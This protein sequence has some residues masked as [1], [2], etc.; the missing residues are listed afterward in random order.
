ML[1]ANSETGVPVL[2]P[3]CLCGLSGELGAVQGVKSFSIKSSKT[4]E[5]AH[6]PRLDGI[7]RMEPAR[8]AHARGD[9]RQ[10]L[11]HRLRD[12]SPEAQRFGCW[13]NRSFCFSGERSQ[14]MMY[15]IYWT[16][17]PWAKG[18]RSSMKIVLMP[19]IRAQPAMDGT[20]AL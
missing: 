2:E 1:A 12:A 10:R 18:S 13:K 14:A 19:V 3:L 8:L 5:H 6:D 7:S 4:P 20:I 17:K 15:V 9:E 11:S 16:I